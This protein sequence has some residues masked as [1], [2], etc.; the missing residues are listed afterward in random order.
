M[1]LGSLDLVGQI[2]SKNGVALT[3]STTYSVLNSLSILFTAIFSRVLLKKGFNNGQYVGIA[4]LLLGS[5][6][7]GYGKHNAS[8]PSGNPG[9]E[10]GF[11]DDTW[12]IGCGLVLAATVLDGVVFC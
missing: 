8:S 1:F 12:M 6:L 5:I 7:Y 4:V 9:E 2:L 3:D 11:N 10:G